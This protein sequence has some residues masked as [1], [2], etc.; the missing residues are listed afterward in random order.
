MTIYAIDTDRHA[1]VAVWG[2]GSGDVAATVAPVPRNVQLTQALD[3]ANRLTALSKTLWRTYT[4]PGTTADGLDENSEGWRRDHERQAFDAVHA[5]LTEPNLPTGE[6]LMRSYILVEETAHDD[7]LKMFRAVRANV[8]S[9]EWVKSH[10]FR[11]T[12]ATIL[13]GD[14]QTARQIADQLGHSRVSMTQD[15]YLGA[16]SETPGLPKRWTRSWGRA[17]PNE[18]RRPKVVGKWW[19]EWVTTVV[20]CALTWAFGRPRG[21]RTHNPRI[22]SPLLCQ[23]S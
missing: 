6:M 19:V 3:L 16:R 22:K 5:A 17:R 9:L 11:K 12:L 4:D 7:T 2:T 13:D 23:L 1:L 20:M 18:A 21:T 14:G 15:G 8:S 10:N